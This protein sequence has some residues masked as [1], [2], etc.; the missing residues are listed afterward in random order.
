MIPMGI[1]HHALG[2]KKSLSTFPSLEEYLVIRFFEIQRYLT[3][4]KN[5]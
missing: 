4:P 1:V 5:T 3:A 2:E